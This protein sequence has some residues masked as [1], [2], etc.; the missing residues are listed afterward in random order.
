MTWH[1]LPA[2][3]MPQFEGRRVWLDPKTFNPAANIPDR[4]IYAVARDGYIDGA[5]RDGRFVL[6]PTDYVYIDV[7]EPPTMP[8]E[9]G[10]QYL[11]IEVNE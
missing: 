7:P 8:T 5:T 6:D 3:R 9:Y 1:E 4:I 11:L 2:A 10:D